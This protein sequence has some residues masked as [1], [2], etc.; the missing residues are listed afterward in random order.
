M[1]KRD[2]VYTPPRIE[3]IDGTKLLELLGPAQGYASGLELEAT[4]LNLG[5]KKR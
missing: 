2:G 3:T 4:E 1:D 5:A